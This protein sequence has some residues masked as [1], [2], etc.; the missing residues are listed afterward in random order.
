MAVSE[1]DINP[2][3]PVVY[4]SGGYVYLIVPI[5]A[6]GLY[7]RGFTE[8]TINASFSV[9]ST[10]FLNS[11][12]INYPANYSEHTTAMSRFNVRGDSNT[13]PMSNVAGWYNGNT[14]GINAVP[15]E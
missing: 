7:D 15:T 8:G 6:Q 4:S 14:S 11:N 3:L 1:A 2:T 9:D 5:Y 12:N 13:S 10:F